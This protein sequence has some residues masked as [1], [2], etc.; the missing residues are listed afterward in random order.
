MAA[1]ASAPQKLLVWDFDWSLINNN[2]DVWVLHFLDAI[3]GAWYWHDATHMNDNI[4]QEHMES[5]LVRL[6]SGTPMPRKRCWRI[7]TA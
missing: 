4:Q 7:L 2:C 6:Q 5:Q 3:D 1:L